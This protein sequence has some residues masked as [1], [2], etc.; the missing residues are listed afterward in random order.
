MNIYA[1]TYDKDSGKG[2]PFYPTIDGKPPKTPQEKPQKKPNKDDKK[3]EHIQQQIPFQPLPND[4][5]KFDYNQYDDDIGQH[6]H[7]QQNPGPGFF[8]PDASKNQYPDYSLYEHGGHQ[9]PIGKPQS[10]ELYNVL[11][12]NTQNLPP[13]IRLDQLLQHIQGQDPNQGHL[14]HGQNVQLPFSNVHQNGVNYPYIE[15]HPSNDHLGLPQRPTGGLF[16][17]S[18]IFHNLHS[19][20]AYFLINKLY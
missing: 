2:M 15:H 16:I 12:P 20:F 17:L 4:P 10:P 9:Q 3:T 8:N 19:Y 11:G 18:Y 7:S 13:H 5:N 14:I 6:H 1:P